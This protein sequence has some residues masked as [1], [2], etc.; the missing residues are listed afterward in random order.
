M[1][2]LHNA[3]LQIG[4]TNIGEKCENVDLHSADSTIQAV[5]YT[6]VCEVEIVILTS[7]TKGII[8]DMALNLVLAS[9]SPR[10]RELL[11]FTAVPFT[12]QVADIDE[13][14]LASEDPVD[15]VRRLATAKAQAVAVNLDADAVVLGSDTIVV[16][17]DVLL[18]KPSDAADAT[19]ML[20]AIRGQTHQVVT[21]FAFVSHAET[22]LVSHETANL[23][24]RAFT[25][26]EIDAYIAS[27]DPMDKAGAYAIQNNTFNP[28]ETLNGC[29]STVMGLPLCEV[30]LALRDL[31]FDPQD[32]FSLNDA[33]EC[34]CSAYAA[35]S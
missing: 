6:A 24:I 27:G 13:T 32:N 28:V 3:G 26:A 31:G 4:H 17:N 25:D 19:R 5:V 15:Y 20:T 14:P 7:C 35:T 22:L 16:H 8:P 11:G 33:L 10:R 18:G 23:Q 34:G 21:A 9:Q 2:A 30:T 12:V 1:R 29:F